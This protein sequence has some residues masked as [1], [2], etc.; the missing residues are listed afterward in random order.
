MNTQKKYPIYLKKSVKPMCEMY[1]IMPPL[2]FILDHDVLLRFSSE[3]PS[4]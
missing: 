3:S 2:Y 1:V 4:R